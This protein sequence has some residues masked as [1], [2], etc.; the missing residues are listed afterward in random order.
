MV[1]FTLCVFCH[2]NFLKKTGGKMGCVY[3]DFHAKDK[4]RAFQA[5]FSAAGFSFLQLAG[6]LLSLY[7][8]YR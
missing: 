5:L 1:D 4:L 6:L 8:N 2:N 7:A 3:F